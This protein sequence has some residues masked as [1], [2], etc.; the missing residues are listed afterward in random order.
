MKKLLL[1]VSPFAILVNWNISIQIPAILEDFWRM[2]MNSPVFLLSHIIGRVN[3]G[4]QKSE[5]GNWKSI[6][7][8]KNL[9]GYSP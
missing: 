8:Q 4:F 7:G 1:R 9:A 5:T 2:G 3:S 6:R